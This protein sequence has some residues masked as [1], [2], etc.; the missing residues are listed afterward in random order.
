[1]LGNHIQ[2]LYFLFSLLSQI[3]NCLVNLSII[4]EDCSSPK[5]IKI[6][7][8]ETLNSFCWSDFALSHLY[9][10]RWVFFTKN[11]QNS[12]NILIQLSKLKLRLTLHHCS[13]NVS[14]HDRKI[15]H[16]RLNHIEGNV[17]CSYQRA[18]VKIML[19]PI[20]HN[21]LNVSKLK[22][23]ILFNHISWGQTLMQRNWL[24]HNNT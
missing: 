7:S 10:C 19:C 20:T 5:L 9:L 3:L 4:I 15:V 22:N 1:M 16:I 12:N 21:F 13:N 8:L 18:D 6:L 23:A 14:G 11:L 17:S 2:N 24:F